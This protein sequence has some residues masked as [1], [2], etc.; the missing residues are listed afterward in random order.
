[1]SACLLVLLSLQALPVVREVLSLPVPPSPTPHLPVFRPPPSLE[2][3]DLPEF[4]ARAG[5]VVVVEDGTAFL[6][7]SLAGLASHHLVSWLRLP[8]MSVLS[9]GGLVFSS[10]PRLEVTVSPGGETWQLEIR[11]VTQLDA[12]QYQCQVNTNTRLST[13]I[14]LSVIGQCQYCTSITIRTQLTA[15]LFNL[16]LFQIIRSICNILSH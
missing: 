3:P 1:M 14:S 5:Q 8:D 6:Q 16:F 12:G 9:V 11:N 4:L 2:E 15:G 7:C 10:D 13:V